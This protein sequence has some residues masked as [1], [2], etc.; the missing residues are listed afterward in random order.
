VRVVQKRRSVVTAV[1]VARLDRQRLLIPVVA[2]AVIVLDQLTK[3][4]ALHHLA[5]SSR[6]VIGPSYLVLTYNSGAAFSLGR[7][8]TPIVETV[9]VALVV[10]LLA[11]S[12]NLSR[13]GSWPVAVGLGLL[14]GGA[15]GNLTDRLF[16]HI[17]GHPS[18]VIDFVQAVSWWPVF[19]VA[20]ASI[21]VGVI[22]LI[23]TYA[24][25]TGRP[26]QETP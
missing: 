8:I 6:H 1:G 11:L 22:V 16:R 20:D 13:S 9:A 5:E 19:N 14:L 3:T 12:R 4:W 2:V 10:W 26:A 24:V 25:R 7:G 21:V 23:V 17:P 15:L 18:S